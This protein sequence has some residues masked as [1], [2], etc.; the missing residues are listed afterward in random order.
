MGGLLALLNDTLLPLFNFD[1]CMNLMSKLMI[2]LN[3]RAIF[4]YACVF[5]VFWFMQ[6]K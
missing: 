3:N 1:N 4:V 5:G 6:D 2:I